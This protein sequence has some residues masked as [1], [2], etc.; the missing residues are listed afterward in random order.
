MPDMKY[1]NS[2]KFTMSVLNIL[3]YSECLSEKT[4]RKCLIEGKITDKVNKQLKGVVTLVEKLREEFNS[5]L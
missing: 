2:L 5:E 1:I 3:Q 4:K